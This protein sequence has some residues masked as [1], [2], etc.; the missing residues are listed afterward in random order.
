MVPG[1]QEVMLPFLR[2]VEKAGGQPVATKE[3]VANLAE[4][5][6]L[7][8][9]EQSELLPSGRQTRF[10][11][12]VAWAASHLRAARLLESAGRGLVTLTDRGRKLL[13]AIRNTRP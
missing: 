4:Q 10:A 11:N 1:F 6:G 8:E 7:S 9:D 2:L 12:R 5:L 13:S 3:A